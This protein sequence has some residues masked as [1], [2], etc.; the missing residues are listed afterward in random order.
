MFLTVLHVAELLQLPS[1]VSLFL[2]EWKAVSICHNKLSPPPS[3]LNQ[4]PDGS[5]LWRQGLISY[6]IFRLTWQNTSD[7]QP[8][9]QYRTKEIPKSFN[10]CLFQICMCLSYLFIFNDYHWGQP[11]DYSKGWQRAFLDISQAFISFCVVFLMCLFIFFPPCL[12]R[13]ATFVQGFVSRLEV[14]LSDNSCV[15]ISWLSLCHLLLQWIIRLH[16]RISALV[17]L[18]NPRLSSVTHKLIKSCEPRM[19]R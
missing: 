13:T 5:Q 1:D 12:Q 16:W 19:K 4:S 8:H 6:T 3:S 9:G 7:L 17:C 15:G 2:A 11:G 10:V 14:V 18:R